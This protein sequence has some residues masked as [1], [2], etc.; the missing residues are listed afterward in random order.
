MAGLSE[1]RSNSGFLGCLTSERQMTLM[2]NAQAY[3]P[4]AGGAMAAALGH[5]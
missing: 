1:S 2:K 4:S 5:A 3:P